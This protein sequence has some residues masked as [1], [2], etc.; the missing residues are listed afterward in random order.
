MGTIYDAIY[1]P[2][3]NTPAEAIQN[4]HRIDGCGRGDTALRSNLDGSKRPVNSF[5]P[6]TQVLHLLPIQLEECL[7]YQLHAEASYL[8]SVLLYA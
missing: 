2:I 3:T 4:G 5:K 1:S 8:Y 7:G 6:F